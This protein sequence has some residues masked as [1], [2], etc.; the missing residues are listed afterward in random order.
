MSRKSKQ[1][2]NTYNKQTFDLYYNQLSNLAL[3]VFKWENLPTEIDYRFLEWVLYTRGYCLFF[4]DEV[5]EKYLTLECAIGG[6]FNVYQIPKYRRAFS[7][8]GYQAS[9]NDKNSVIIFN[10]Y[11]HTPT[12]IYIQQ[13]AR[14]LALIERTI[15]VNTNAQ[16]TPVMIVC[17]ENQQLSMKNLYQQYDG[18]EPFIFAN[19]NLGISE[20]VKVLN[21]QAPALFDKLQILKHQ[22]FNEA[23]TFLGI[24]NSNSDKKERLVEAEVGSNYGNVEMQRFV[25]LN[26]RRQACEQINQMF[27]LNVEVKY[28]SELPTM[29]NSS[30]LGIQYSNTETTESE[31][32]SNG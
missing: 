12:N 22:I 10:D 16:K 9:R 14:R 27:G 29:L 1:L 21:T 19:K 8:S 3:N 4:Q 7:V 23:L 28:N 2:T 6:N 15:D 18:N 32:E 17:D 26:A 5:T 11:L 13:F 24:E 30:N 20:G 25:F 31:V